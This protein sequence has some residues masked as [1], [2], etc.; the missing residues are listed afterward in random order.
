MRFEEF[1]GVLWEGLR[2][3]CIGFPGGESILVLRLR[4]FFFWNIVLGREIGACSGL[5]LGL[6]SDFGRN[7]RVC[8]VGDFFLCCV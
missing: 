3:L 4:N 1:R 2:S 5:C 6:V 8:L 7:W